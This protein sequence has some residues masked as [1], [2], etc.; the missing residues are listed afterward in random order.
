MLINSSVF[1]PDR[2]ENMILKDPGDVASSGCF[3]VVKS[4]DDLKV[5]ENPGLKKWMQHKKFVVFGTGGSCLGGQCISAIFPGDNVRF[6]NNLDPLT[7]KKVF[8]EINFEETGFLCISKSGE[9]LETICLTLSALDLT[10]KKEDKFVFITENKPSSLREIANRFDFLCL[11]HPGDIGGRFSVFSIV[12]MLP[13][14]L[15][16]IDPM[17]IR[18]GGRKIL[19]KH[20]SEPKSGAA[21]VA[22]NFRDGK[23]LHVSFFYSDRLETF[24]KW[25]AQ[26]Y[27]ESTGK[28]GVGITPITAMG[29]VDQHSQ[30]QLYLDGCR[31]KCFSF[32]WENQKS[33][34]SFRENIPSSFSYLEG[35]TAADVFRAQQGGTMTS[36]LEKNIPVRKIEIP[37]ITPEI[38]G[39][40]FMYFMLE[41]VFV[42][43]EIN[44]NPFDQP[45][46]E[47][48]K[49]ITKDI[50]SLKSDSC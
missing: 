21:F 7:L 20:L 11:D 34:F 48:G 40:L 32:F 24:G 8:S 37:E 4:S 10:E 25:L 45:A 30:L 44:V 14:A 26:L 50:L 31:D 27:A 28:S 49:K 41:V 17:K 47:Y 22:K 46:V 19:E 39:E 42:C 13:A 5:F 9:T 36:L 43:K 2:Y 16:G 18:F 12:G 3:S 35:K 1:F 23:N 29:A 15:C 33:D 6:V 38:L